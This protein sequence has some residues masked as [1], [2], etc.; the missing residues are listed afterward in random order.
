[1]DRQP[2]RPRI[3]SSRPEVLEARGLLAA[4]LSGGLDIVIGLG[5]VSR[6]LATRG[7]EV[8][9]SIA[10]H[11][12]TTF[13]FGAEAAGNYLLEIRHVGDGLTI[14]ATGPAGSA[15]LDPGPSGSDVT[16]ALPLK[17]GD[18]RIKASAGGDRPVFVD[19]E[20]LLT[21]G[22]GQSAAIGTTLGAPSAPLPPAGLPGTAMPSAP[23]ASTAPASPPGT[24]S[25]SAVSANWGLAASPSTA[26]VIGRPVGRFDPDPAI[27]PVGPTSPGGG[28][29]LADAGDGLPVG[30]LRA[31]VPVAE[32]ESPASTGPT[33]LLAL[34]VLGDAREDAAA[35]DAS[36]WLDRLARF[37]D[38]ATAGP[39]APAESA[40]PAEGLA[41]AAAAVGEPAEPISQASTLSAA[42]PGLVAAGAAISSVVHRW[43]AGRKTPAGPA[44]QAYPISFPPSRR[45]WM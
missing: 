1:M 35:L 25:P 13:E 27:S 32:D 45:G 11:G 18:Y 4:G 10:A 12:S 37:Q 21:S 34:E 7:V 20:L 19:W 44:S 6:A 16:I 23:A 36:A 24:P 43:R 22:V 8:A 17:A 40:G 26:S 9:A 14:Q 15:S 31:L 28:V 30:A 42:S 33:P 41:V 2:S 38:W 5:E 3:L 29:A 39:I